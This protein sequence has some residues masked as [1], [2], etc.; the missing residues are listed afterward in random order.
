GTTQQTLEA[1]LG[2]HGDKQAAADD[3]EIDDQQ[4]SHAHQSELFAEDR[5]DKVGV[6]FGQKLQLGLGALQPA[7]A[8]HAT[9]TD[10]YLGLDDVIAATQG[11]FLGVQQHQYPLALVVVHQEEP[12]Y[13]HEGA[14]QH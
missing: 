4:Q 6:A 5:K 3:V 9:R 14:D 7:F 2:L 12:E 1:V 10:R 11:V 8:K 13:R